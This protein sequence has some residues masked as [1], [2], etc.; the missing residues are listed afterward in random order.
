MI[1]KHL[2][3]RIY[4]YFVV[5]L[6]VVIATIGLVFTRLN[7]SNIMEVYQEQ[8]STL[9]DNISNQVRSYEKQNNAEGFFSYLT[10]IEDFGEMQG[11]DIWITT[12]PGSEYSMDSS[13]ANVDI[14]QVKVPDET[15]QILN[16]AYQGKTGVYNNFDSI[17]DKTMLH[18]ARPVKNSAGHVM[19][20]VLLNATVDTQESYVYQYQR[21]MMLSVVIGV[22]LAFALALFFSGQISRPVAEMKRIALTMAAGNYQ[23]K[24]S[25]KRSDE[26]GQLAVSLDVLGDRLVA[27]EQMR[28]N[29]EQNRRDFFS[30]VSHEL[31]TPITV[32]KGYAETLADGYVKEATKQQDYYERMLAECNSMERL[33]TDLLTLSKM[34][35]PDFELDF[36]ILNIIAV[37]QDTLR[38]VRVL[39]AEKQIQS[40][41]VYDDECSFIRGDY[42]RIRQLFIIILQNAIKYSEP[43]T[44]VYVHVMKN[45][46]TIQVSIADEGVGI[47]TE[48]L[49]NIFEKFYRGQNH[50]E[51]DGSGLGL[52][53]ARHIVERHEGRIHA[54]SEI[55]KGSTFIID[56]P[57][58]EPPDED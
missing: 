14:E 55:G 31:R 28:D 16:E 54:E 52:V 50:T 22:F 37:A 27:A 17:Y 20:V 42:D 10:A 39:M 11:A 49:E 32:V 47:A 33:V 13:F 48:D 23:V 46:D 58:C 6:I 21:Y 12:C 25:I 30:N 4:I 51:K 43:D 26:I 56:L 29:L 34:Q 36:E 19:G 45:E 9:A 57:A 41:L 24:T 18:L 35:N 3:W 38:S 15:Q 1:K 7:Q 44:H 53:V 40:E 2:F 8:L 5:V